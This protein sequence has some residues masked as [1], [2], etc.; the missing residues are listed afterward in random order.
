MISTLCFQVADVSSLNIKNA[1]H[2]LNIT[3]L[4][5]ANCLYDIRV[6]MRSPLANGEHMWSLPASLTIRTK[7]SGASNTWLQYILLVLTVAVREN[8]DHSNHHGLL[9]DTS[10][11]L[12][13]RM[14]RRIYLSRFFSFPELF[15]LIFISIYSS[16]KI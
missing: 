14:E 5:Y 15:H 3:G 16:V 7:P 6:F 4:K 2:K 9:T 11:L 8:F 12:S 13:Q 10:V 1:T